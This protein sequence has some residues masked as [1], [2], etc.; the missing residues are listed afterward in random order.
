MLAQDAA[1]EL[2]PPQRVSINM[3]LWTA[4][5]DRIEPGRVWVLGPD[6]AAVGPGAHDY[7]QIVMLGWPAG[8]EVNPFRL[9]AVPV[10]G[11]RLPGVMARAIPGRL[12]LRVSHPALAAG[13]DFPLLAA[14]AGEAY[15]EGRAASVAV[16]CAFATAGAETFAGLAAEAKI[17][18]GAHKKIALGQ[19]GEYECEDLDCDACSE[20]PVCDRIRE[21]VVIRRKQRI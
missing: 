1:L 14:A 7:A 11:E 19:T 15:H 8:M 12:W 6:L 5:P 9:A 2:G 17:L 3:V 16:E 20:K 10:A 18:V 4:P 21:A 13:L